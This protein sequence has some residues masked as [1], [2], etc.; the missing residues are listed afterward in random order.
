MTTLRLNPIVNFFAEILSSSTRCRSLL[1]S[2]KGNSWSRMYLRLV[3][4]PEKTVLFM[5]RVV[6]QVGDAMQVNV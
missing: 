6:S 1:T 2:R 5:Y 4:L 3:M